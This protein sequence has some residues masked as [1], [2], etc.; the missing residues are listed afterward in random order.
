MMG[1]IVFSFDVMLILLICGFK[2]CFFWFG[3]NNFRFFFF[4]G[5]FWKLKVG[6]KGF[7][8]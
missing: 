5:Y 8:I 4:M 1:F 3:G 6:D 7:G 2:F